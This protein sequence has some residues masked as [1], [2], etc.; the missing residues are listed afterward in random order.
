MSDV[1]P[2]RLKKA[3]ELRKLSQ[4]EAATLSGLPP[5]SISHFEA[6][7]RKPSFDNLRRLARALEVTTDFLLG[8]AETPDVSTSADPLYRHGQ[9]MSA[10]DRKLAEGIFQLLAEKNRKKDG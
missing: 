8:L 5:T 10:E 1:F 7:A 2:E 3:R 6:G 9:L 4:G